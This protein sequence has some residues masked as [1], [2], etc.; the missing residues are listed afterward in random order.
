MTFPVG[1]DILKVIRER[2]DL[3]DNRLVNGAAIAKP[4]AR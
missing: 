2:L 3:A 1:I 4:S